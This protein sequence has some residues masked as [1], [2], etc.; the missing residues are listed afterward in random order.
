MKQVTAMVIGAGLRG[1]HVYSAYALEHPDEFKVIAV[2]EPDNT[3]R[4]EFAALHHI[5]A[6]KCFYSYKECLAQEKMADCVLVCT[7]DRMHYEPV[8]E[9]L[10]KGYHVLC[11]KPMST[12]E[13]EIM[14][15]GLM[16]ER[17][18]RIFMICHVLRYSSFFTKIK[19][20]IDSGKIGTIVN[21][22]HIEEVGFWHHAHSFVRGNWRN[23]N[24]TSPMIL[25]KCCHDMDILL[26]LMGSKC[27]KI[28][29]F[30]ELSYFK[31]ENA[32]AHAPGRCMDGC[33]HR[34]ECA[35]Y[36]P[37]FYLE[38]PKAVE[39]GLAYA[40]SEDISQGKL[41]EALQKGPYGRCV[42][43][44]DNNVV[45]HQIV[46]LEFENKSVASLTMSA[47][48]KVC[49]RKINIMGT[50][51]QIEGEM[52]N[53]T[54]VV[55]DFVSGDE[56]T[57]KLNAPARGHNGS[58]NNMMKDFV[59]MVASGK[60]ITGKTDASVSV[61]SHL[62]SLAAERSRVQGTTIDFREFEKEIAEQCK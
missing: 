29:S 46:N 13:T 34:N 62:M 30:G 60:T 20:L 7:Q 17:C 59:G 28:S 38:H 11:E 4:M 10:Q 24:E 19:E 18:N 27:T 44:C 58:D 23:S 51:A 48:S 45:D 57:I 35:F 47:F 31:E 1:G 5:P 52:D 37:R 42:F 22:H 50:K 53:N 16:A 61:E 33:E 54:I 6:E 26:W 12:N 14:N 39:D 55:R 3:R 43:R 36:A 49:T 25:Q 32:P 41:L 40:V 15:M 2:A 8:M 21:I 56:E 9:A